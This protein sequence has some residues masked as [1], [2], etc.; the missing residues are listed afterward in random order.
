MK[1]AQVY[2]VVFLFLTII[3][4][5]NDDDTDGGLSIVTPDPTEETILDPASIWI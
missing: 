4:C 3:S 1:K 2:G 5:N